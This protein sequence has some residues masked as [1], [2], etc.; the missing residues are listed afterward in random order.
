M[1]QEKLPNELKLILYCARTKIDTSLRHKI[2][3]LLMV[4]L[5][6]SQIIEQ[7]HYHG[8]LP[9]LY[10]NINKIQ[11]QAIP[12]SAFTAL[13]TYCH[14]TLVKNMYLWKEFL[15]IQDELNRAGIKVIPL[16]GIIL[17]ETL[18]HNLG[19]RPMLDID[20]LVQENSLSFAE[21]QLQ[22]LGYEKRLE[23]LSENYWRKYRHHFQLYNPHKNINLEVHWALAPPHPNRLNLKEAWERSHVQI[24]D[25]REILTLSAEDTLLFLCLHI[26]RQ[27]TTL[28]HLQLK[29]LCD[30][31]ELILQSPNLD[32]E[33]IINKATTWRIRGALFYVYLLTEKYLSTPWPLKV[34]EL[35]GLRALPTKILNLFAERRFVLKRKYHIKPKSRFYASLSMLLMADTIKDYFALGLQKLS[36][37]LSKLFIDRTRNDSDILEK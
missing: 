35:L 28:Q 25:H 12:C 30:I 3:E 11:K 21:K 34:T 17:S 7:S 33:Y 16:K 20:V 6:W 19:L 24:I 10:F 1:L 14:V 18:Y 22:L 31:N 23:N 4:L 32:W 26:G 2:Q 8:I 36:I 9:L 29:N 5:D 15:G 37:V 13:K 27:I